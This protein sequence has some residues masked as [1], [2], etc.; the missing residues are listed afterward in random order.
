[1]KFFEKDFYLYF[2]IANVLN[3]SRNLDWTIMQIR[4][5]ILHSR[6]PFSLKCTNLN[7][8]SHLILTRTVNRSFIRS[9]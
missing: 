2:Y 7:Q 1:M 6:F 5:Y 3:I 9:T 8:R 4:Y